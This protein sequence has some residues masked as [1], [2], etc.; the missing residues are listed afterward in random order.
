MISA[1]LALAA[2]QDSYAPDP[3]GFIRNWLVLAP[4][5]C[6]SEGN[7]A[8]EIDAQ[9]VKDEAKLAPRAG[10]K[11]AAGKKTLVWT[12]HKTADFFIDFKASFDKDAG[13][14]VIGYAVAYVH[15]DAEMDGVRMKVGS[16]DQCKAYL[17]GA[18]VIR[19][20]EGRTLEKDQ[21]TANVTL[22]K[23]AN[24]VLLKV[25]NESNNWQGC[26]RFTTQDGAALKNLKV[27]L[28]P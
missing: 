16:N 28:V 23:G 9:Q 7:G 25:I 14:N 22:K 21:N 4:I 2:V 3:E 6:E 27:T 24:V 5:P 18:Q 20:D 8:V 11:A 19:F 1:L 26:L 10:D 15:A 13:E 17:N 12:A